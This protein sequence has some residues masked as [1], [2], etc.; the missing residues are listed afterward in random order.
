M[1]GV[2]CKVPG[3]LEGLAFPLLLKKDISLYFV[4][5]ASREKYLR[6]VFLLYK[7]C[8]YIKL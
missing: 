3:R 2:Y 4:N 8:F 6:Q 7:F 1:P 5:K